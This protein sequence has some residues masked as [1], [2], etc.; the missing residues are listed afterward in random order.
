MSRLGAC[1]MIIDPH[2]FET[3]LYTVKDPPPVNPVSSPQLSSRPPD[4]R[5]SSFSHISIQPLSPFNTATPSL[6][7]QSQNQSMP[8]QPTLPPF[9]EAFARFEP[10]GPSS[11]QNSAIP[12]SSHAT[13]SRSS[14]DHANMDNAKPDNFKANDEKLNPDPV[15]QMLA[16]RAASNHNLKSLMKV[17]A[18]GNA[19]Q[20]QLADFQSYIDELNDVIKSRNSTSHVTSPLPSV[21]AISNPSTLSQTQPS[22]LAVSTRPL[23]NYTDPQVPRSASELARQEPPTSYYS[24]YSQPAKP[25]TQISHRSD[26]SAIVFDIGGSGDRFS[27]PRLSILEY[28]P[29]GTQVLVSFLIIRKGSEAACKGYKDTASYYQPI[30][31]RLS[32]SQPRILEPLA[33]VVASQ[34]EVR[35][36]M[37]SVFDRML[38]AQNAFLVTRLPRS[39]DSIEVEKEISVTPSE[40]KVIQTIYSPPNSLVPLVISK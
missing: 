11:Y 30:T 14:Y 22:S 21:T 1:S 4:M 32:T 38:P 37:N 40:R 5:Y 35:K 29:G 8:S 23:P 34:E 18:S 2:V 20:K 9:K 12:A 6:H 3:T 33:R 26:I 31:M 10:Q 17:V 7:V 16:A 15:I 39:M 19:T 36:Y 28:L 25:R 24:H 27:F 13:I